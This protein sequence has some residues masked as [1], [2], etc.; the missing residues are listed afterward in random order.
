MEQLISTPVKGPE[1]I[2][3][4]LIP[5]FVIGMIDVTLAVVMGKYLFFVPLRGS[6]VLLF[7]MA[8]VFLVGVLSLGILISVVTK[9]QLLAS[10]VAML[11]T[12]LPSFL[13][14]GFMFAISNMPVV[15]QWITHVVPAR[16]LVTLLKAIYLKGVGLEVLYVEAG[17]LT[18]F[19]AVMLTLAI[20]KF[21]KKLE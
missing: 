16:Y 8:A 20:V 9:S 18:A 14:S 13:L 4:K 7:G 17:L 3:G 6:L 10:Q 1:L 21:R 11:V 12:F 5:Y 15:I 2:V 19:S